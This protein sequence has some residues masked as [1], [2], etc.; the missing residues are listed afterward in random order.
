MFRET[1][2][3][4]DDFENEKACREVEKKEFE[5]IMYEAL[6]QCVKNWNETHNVVTDGVLT[7]D[8]TNPYVLFITKNVQR[9]Q[10]AD[11][12]KLSFNISS[13]GKVK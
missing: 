3:K 8:A 7:L 6:K 11:S 4:I 13:N 9:K 2:K 12:I 1:R 5:T 10:L